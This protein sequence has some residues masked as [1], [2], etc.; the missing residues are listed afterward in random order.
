MYSV[1]CWEVCHRYTETLSSTAVHTHTA[2]T[3]GVRPPGFEVFC[4]RES[5]YTSN[6]LFC[7]L[8]VWQDFLRDVVLRLLSRSKNF[9]SSKHK[10]DSSI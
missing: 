10:T 6:A 9:H 4:I 5:G 1:R 2:Y 3:M 8:E 7:I